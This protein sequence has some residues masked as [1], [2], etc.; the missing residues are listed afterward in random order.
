[1]RK[2]GSSADLAF[3]NALSDR[4]HY[5]MCWSPLRFGTDLVNRGGATKATGPS[6]A[7]KVVAV[8]ASANW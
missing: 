4:Y 1:M 7:G 3:E 8:Y 5:Q 2:H 6:L